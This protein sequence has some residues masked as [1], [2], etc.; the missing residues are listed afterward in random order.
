MSK[1]SS[2]VLRG[3]K[4]GVIRKYLIITG[5]LRRSS[6][7]RRQDSAFKT[8]P[9][10]RGAKNKTIG[11]ISLCISVPSVPSVVKKR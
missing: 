11:F 4:Q 2:L 10:P 8:P 1:L 7:Q 6:L 5:L 3:T 9:P